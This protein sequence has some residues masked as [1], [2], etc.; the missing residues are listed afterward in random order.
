MQSKAGN[1]YELIETHTVCD[2]CG[3][4]LDMVVL[5]ITRHQ[6][7]MVCL[8]ETHCGGCK[9]TKLFTEYLNTG[10]ITK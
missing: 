3:K 8:L 4:D 10:A 5:K 6:E 2:R 1:C 9:E 7:H